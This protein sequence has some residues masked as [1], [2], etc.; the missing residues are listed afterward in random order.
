[1]YKFL[2]GEPAGGT[3]CEDLEANCAAW[4][5]SGECESN[6]EFMGSN[7]RL[8]CQL[9]EGA[10]NVSPPLKWNFEYFLLTRGGR[11]HTRWA[12]GTDLLKQT[13]QIEELLAAKQ[14]L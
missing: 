11:V 13:K 14:E 3:G 1:M 4:A 7:C 8:S 2:K 5:S 9:C 6:P 10:S 12:T